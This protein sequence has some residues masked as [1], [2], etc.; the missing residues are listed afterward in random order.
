M[1]QVN[2]DSYE[3]HPHTLGDLMSEA[4]GESYLSQYN[5]AEESYSNKIKEYGDLANKNTLTADKLL[6][7][8]GKIGEKVDKLKP[9]IDI[10]HLS[11]TCKRKLSQIYTEVTTGRI[12]DIKSK[13]FEKGLAV[14]EDIISL[15]C[16]VYGGFHKKNKVTKNNG[17]IKGT[18]DVDIESEDLVIDAKGSWDIFTFDVVTGLAINP[19][20]HWQGDGYMWLWGRNSFRLVYG[21]INTPKHM[22]A[23]EE[24]ILLYDFIGTKEDYEEACKDLRHNMTY[25]DLSDE[26]KIH[27][28]DV[29]RSEERIEKIKTQVPVWREYLNNYGKNKSIEDENQ[30]QEERDLENRRE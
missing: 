30:N 5:K 13:Y 4:K 1:E 18:C 3:F 19:K 21:L 15:Y 24:R 29:K 23:R 28:F 26:R 20:Y 6:E 17:F 2:F 22:I 7:Q 12:K 25:D 9:L 8:C 14:E 27:I 10:P 11:A 16:R